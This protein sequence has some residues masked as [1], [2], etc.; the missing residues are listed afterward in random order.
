MVSVSTFSFVSIPVV[1]YGFTQ[2]L[3]N[4]LNELAR[5][6]ALYLVLMEK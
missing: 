4:N 3:F 6:T 1:F 5:C 2:V